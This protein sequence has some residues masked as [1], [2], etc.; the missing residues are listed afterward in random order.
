MHQLSNP[1]HSPKATYA[2]NGF[3]LSSKVGF[4]FVQRQWTPRELDL[5]LGAMLLRP[6]SMKTAKS[7]T[8]FRDRTSGQSPG[9]RPWPDPVNL[10]NEGSR[11]RPS[12]CCASAR[13]P[14]GR[15]ECVW[16]DRIAKELGEG[17]TLAKPFSCN[18]RRKPARK[19][20]M[21][22]IFTMLGP[23]AGPIGV[24][25]ASSALGG[26]GSRRI[27]GGAPGDGVGWSI[28]RR[29]GAGGAHQEGVSNLGPHRLVENLCS[30]GH[31]QKSLNNSKVGLEKVAD[32][33][34]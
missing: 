26:G 19:I 9:N 7:I 28:G 24:V 15:I 23:D 12:S 14:E 17:W 16:P 29:R 27:R 32:R 31:G 33:A 18:P 13:N 1:K 30:L 25:R 21:L 8:P 5:I 2:L 22:Q 11:G 10:S 34:W 4:V 6:M 20:P 3:V